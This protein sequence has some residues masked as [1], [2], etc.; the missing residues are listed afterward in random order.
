MPLPFLNLMA[1]IIK[2]I[3]DVEFQLDGRG[4]EITEISL[5]QINRVFKI[6][7]VVPEIQ[8]YNGLFRRK[9]RLLAAAVPAAQEKAP[10]NTL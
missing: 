8:Q 7:A 5:A 2:Q 4:E 3:V 10:S 1:G 6:K 9:R